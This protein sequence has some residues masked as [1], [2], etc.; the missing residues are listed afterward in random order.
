MGAVIYS[1]SPLQAFLPTFGTIAIILVIAVVG[2]ISTF[3][4]RKQ[5]SGSRVGLG[6]AGGFLLVVGLG[7]AFLTLLTIVNGHKTVNVLINNKMVAHDN[8]SNGGSGTRFV[9]ETSAGPD[10]YDLNI[11][12]NVYNTAEVNTCYRVTYFPKTV[13]FS[14]P[15]TGNGSYQQVD[16]VTQIEVAAPSA[17]Q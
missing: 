8:R 9:L 14:D 12:E 7:Y 11:P 6:I 10:L 16:S 15:P 1:A 4:G 3:G 2:L 5:G 17:C 13:I